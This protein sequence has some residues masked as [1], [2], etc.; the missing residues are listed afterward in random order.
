MPFDEKEYKRIWYL[1]NRERLLESRRKYRNENR[2]I[3]KNWYINNPEYKS[4]W[5]KKNPWYSSYRN[6][7]N[8][9][10]NKNSKDY[11]NYGGRGIKFFLSIEEIKYIWFRDNARFLKMATIDRIDNNGDYE[12]NNC[13][14][15]EKSE[16]SRKSM[17]ER[18]R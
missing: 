11:K 5:Y 9:C 3:I 2:I 14:F 10:L 13:R 12:L 6:A 1:K 16:N 18:Q 15:I 7:R 4:N 8:R 17:R